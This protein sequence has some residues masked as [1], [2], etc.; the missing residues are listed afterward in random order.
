MCKAGWPRT[1][2]LG[3]A[4]TAKVQ[5]MPVRLLHITSFSLDPMW[6]RR[7]RVLLH[8]GSAASLS[9]AAMTAPEA[10]FLCSSAIKWEEQWHFAHKRK[11]DFDY[12]TYHCLGMDTE[13]W[14]LAIK[15]SFKVLDFGSLLLLL[16][17]S[18]IRNESLN[19]SLLPCPLKLQNHWENALATMKRRKLWSPQHNG[20]A[21][22][23]LPKSLSARPGASGPCRLPSSALA[24]C[25][26]GSCSLSTTLLLE[27]VTFVC[28][29]AIFS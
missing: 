21:A 25:W 27:T 23:P 19:P 29:K 12:N 3:P 20:G 1:P 4:K 24:S 7:A 26:L 5:G 11:V 16:F 14:I 10:V 13:R 17:F 6:H 15:K 22:P 18:S 28:F 8:L 2:A 9:P